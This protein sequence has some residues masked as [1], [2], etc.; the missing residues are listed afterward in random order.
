MAKHS[1]VNEV[2]TAAV[3]EALEKDKSGLVAEIT[4]DVLN[5]RTDSRSLFYSYLGGYGGTSLESIAR[6]HVQ[7]IA[8]EAVKAWIDERADDVR[9]AVVGK[10][11]ADALADSY[12]KRL[13]NLAEDSD[14][15]VRVN[16][17]AP[18]SDE[19]DD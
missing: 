18:R 2:V 6:R 1:R 19:D 16:I 5:D 13:I 9:V 4:A 10:L 15:D 11:S 14:I 8:A 7:D 17:E 12:I 3:I